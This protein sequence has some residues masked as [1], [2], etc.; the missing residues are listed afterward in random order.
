MKV[1]VLLVFLTGACNS[2]TGSSDD[3]SMNTCDG[4]EPVGRG[5][6]EC[7]QTGW[8]CNSCG[9][10]QPSADS[11]CT[12]GSSCDYED[13]EHGCSCS[14]AAD[15]HWRC[16]NETIGSRCPTGAD[17][18]FVG[19]QELVTSSTAAAERAP[20]LSGDTLE[21]LFT[22][23]GPGG[24]LDVWRA[25]RPDGAPGTPF[26]TPVRETTLST[27]AD[28]IDASLSAD[29]L[30]ALVLRSGSIVQTTR[31]SIGAPWSTGAAVPELA[32]FEAP[33]FAVADFATFAELHVVLAMNGD[34]Y[35]ATRPD[36][37][38][39][40]S[41]PVKLA[42]VSSTA[43]DGGPTLSPSGLELV[44][45]SNRGGHYQLYSA[46]RTGLGAPF[47]APFL[48]TVGGTT[49]N[50][51]DPEMS[52]GGT[53]LVYVSDAGGNDNLWTATRQPPSF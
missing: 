51:R 37:T 39:A 11:I 30:T 10:T 49:A 22:R 14:C 42:T 48:I 29:S 7:T 33:D 17:R 32:G 8:R 18:D 15:A 52:S 23:P 46:L 19:E 20:T 34:L 2:L 53:L 5:T 47:G 3:A 31:A 25:T 24:S 38:T 4:P 13:W 16:F 12:P 1:L 36:S 41:T 6:C 27:A 28:E 44:F 50:L 26:A 43:D 21:L 40:W 45:H 35:E 9:F